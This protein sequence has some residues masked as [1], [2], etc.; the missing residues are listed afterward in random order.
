M[1]FISVSFHHCVD[2][3]IKDPSYS[4]VKHANLIGIIHKVIM[5]YAVIHLIYFVVVFTYKSHHFI[6]L[7]RNK[8]IH[9][10]T[11]IHLYSTRVSMLQDTL[12]FRKI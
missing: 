4:L 2:D 3:L 8:L 11:H 12:K 10:R 6:L 9:G 1:A 7:K 5:I